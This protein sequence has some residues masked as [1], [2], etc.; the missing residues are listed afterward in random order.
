MAE[1]S[2]EKAR[3][4]LCKISGA[5]DILAEL[6]FFGS[7]EVEKRKGELSAS[8]ELSGGSGTITYT[9]DFDG[10][11]DCFS[12][13][14][15]SSR[16]E[17]FGSVEDQKKWL[18]S[19]GNARVA[20]TGETFIAGEISPACDSQDKDQLSDPSCFLWTVSVDRHGAGMVLEVR[21]TER[22]SRASVAILCE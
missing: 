3:Q 6:K 4:L 19:K 10:T 18:A 16:A 17:T 13:A 11:E 21:W 8:V 2:A 9:K 12:V 14:L 20:S 22:V 15:D 7:V 5:K 1:A